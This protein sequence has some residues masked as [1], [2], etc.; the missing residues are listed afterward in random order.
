MPYQCFNGREINILTHHM[1]PKGVSEHMDSSFSNGNILAK[2]RK[3]K[4]IDEFLNS[5]YKR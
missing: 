2:K 4:L 5:Y 3:I 1:L